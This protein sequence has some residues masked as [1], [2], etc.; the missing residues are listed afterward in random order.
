MSFR[1]PLPSRNRK[2]R[3]RMSLFCVLAVVA[4]VVMVPRVVS[5]AEL[6]ACSPS[7]VSDLVVES[8]EDLAELVEQT[9]CSEGE[10]VVSWRGGVVFESPIVVGNLTSLSIV[11]EGSGAVLDGGGVTR[12]FEVSQM[13]GNGVRGLVPSFLLSPEP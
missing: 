3:S 11:G 5:G 8:A 10:F 7:S 6:P 4:T 9:N 13:R 1:K 2:C 12:L